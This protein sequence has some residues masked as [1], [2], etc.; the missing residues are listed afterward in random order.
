MNRLRAEQESRNGCL[1]RTSKADS[2]TKSVRCDERTEGDSD[3]VLDKKCLCNGVV[4]N[5]T[6]CNVDLKTTRELLKKLDL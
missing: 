1:C 4:S 2:C 5:K 6:E 3:D